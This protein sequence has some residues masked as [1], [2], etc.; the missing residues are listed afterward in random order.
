MELSGELVSGP[1]FT[2][3]PGPQFMDARRLARMKKAPEKEAVFWY[4]RG[5]TRPRPAAWASVP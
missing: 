4:E 2:H 1:F 5:G 3:I